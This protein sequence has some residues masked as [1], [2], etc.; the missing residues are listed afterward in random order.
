M[1]ELI[2]KFQKS[3]VQQN[4]EAVNPDYSINQQSLK[5][6]FPRETNLKPSVAAA[7]WVMR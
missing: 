2:R 6:M 5:K 4:W 7:L 1:V 3:A